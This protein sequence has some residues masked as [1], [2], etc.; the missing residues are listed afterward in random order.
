VIL[1]LLLLCAVT[2]AADPAPRAETA[3][4]ADTMPPLPAAPVRP[5]DR[6]GDCTAK[7]AAPAGAARDCDAIS[8]PPAYLAYLEEGRV[9][10][11]QLHL[12][13]VASRAVAAADARSCDDALTWRDQ[14]IADAKTPRPVLQRPG[15]QVGVG[16]GVGTLLT[17]GAGW[18]LGQV[19]P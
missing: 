5:P 9:Y 4:P 6:A 13:L 1:T 15:V 19:A 18:A 2:L 17:I 7:A 3:P 8:V 14:V 11:D 12:H 10:G 16:V